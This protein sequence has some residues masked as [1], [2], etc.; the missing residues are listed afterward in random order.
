MRFINNKS[1]ASMKK[2]IIPLIAVVLLSSCGNRGNGELTG[3]KNRPVYTAEDPY[4]MLHI[5]MGSYHMGT[6]DEDIPYAMN[7]QSKVVTVQAF[8]MD[9]TEITNNEYRQFVEWV[10]DSLAHHFLGR[11]LDES[12]NEHFLKHK[13]GDNEGD[14]IEPILINW[15][16]KIDW[17]NP[18]EDYQE[19]L[20]PLFVNITDKR[21]YHY[22][23]IE[24]NTQI[25]DYEYWWIDH[26][27]FRGQIEDYDGIR[28]G[29]GGSYKEFDVEDS[30]TRFKGLYSN[31]PTGYNQGKGA[32]IRHEI[33]NIYPDTLAWIHDFTYSFNE[34]MT[35]NYFWHPA[36]DHYPVVGVSWR[37]AKAFSHWRTQL[38]NSWLISQNEWMFENDFR[39]P[40]EA[41]WEWAARGSFAMSAF[42][43]GGPYPRN[44]NGCFLANYKPGRGNYIDDGGFHTLIVGHYAPNDFGLYDMAGNVAEWCEDAFEESAYNYAH[45]LNM[46]YSYSAIETDGI[47]KKRK[48]IRGGSWKDV[49][50]Y[51]T[52]YARTYEYQDTG[53]SYIGFRNVQTFLGRQKGDNMNSASH[54]Y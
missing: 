2:Y 46:Q 45:D 41:E 11:Q 15:K 33:V 50:Y 30:K 22:R 31:R 35:A 14:F 4:G 3:V 7:H 38:R 16:E 49:G 32:F 44:A 47:A 24:L 21:F 18:D 6:G 19:A 20:A 29:M 54:V 25:L 28:D 42:P 12:E 34:P 5:P 37:Q 52:N 39:L 43:W 27:N 51:I 1:G 13:K 17:E 8:Y 10:R 9:E 26:R 23:Q 48:V 53:K 36:Y 40:N